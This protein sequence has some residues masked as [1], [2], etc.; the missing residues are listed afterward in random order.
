MIMSA[1]QRVLVVE[2]EFLV[3][4]TLQDSLEDWGYEVVG[5]SGHLQDA[6]DL[7]EAEPVDAAII[8]VN[9][10]GQP[11]FPLAARLKARGIPFVLTTGYERSVIPEEF[12]DAAWLQKPVREAELREAVGALWKQE[13][14]AGAG[15]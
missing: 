9:L 14:P 1:R 4:M 8:D 6:M 11:I 2:D 7:L 5:P 13:G 15:A 12:R 3:A 10:A